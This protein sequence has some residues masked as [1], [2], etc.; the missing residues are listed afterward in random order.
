MLLRYNQQ[1][2]QGGLS[3]NCPDTEIK[4]QHYEVGYEFIELYNISD[5]EI[6]IGGFGV[7][8]VN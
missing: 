1:A 4:Y 6:D 3:W 5:E 7:Y 2:L 8:A